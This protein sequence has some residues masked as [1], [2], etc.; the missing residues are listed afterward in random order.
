MT[1]LLKKRLKLVFEDGFLVSRHVFSSD[2]E[3]DPRFFDSIYTFSVFG[4][5]TTTPIEGAFEF[6]YEK[7]EVDAFR[8]FL[9]N[10]EP[11]LADYDPD[12]LPVEDVQKV[13]EVV[14]TFT[15]EDKR[16]AISQ[17]YG[18]HFINVVNLLD[19]WLSELPRKSPY[20]GVIRNMTELRQILSTRFEI[21]NL[22]QNLPESSIEALFKYWI[23]SSMNYITKPFGPFGIIP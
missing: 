13:I 7:V 8:E 20:E 15:P 16:A 9:I 18:F 10:W 23:S 22:R 19:K 12:N 14:K 11:E 3:E 1:D 21:E 5:L 2:F 17:F 4:Q 6:Y